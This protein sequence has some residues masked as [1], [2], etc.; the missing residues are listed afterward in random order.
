[1]PL[2]NDLLEV[3]DTLSGGVHPGF[4]PAHARGVM[5]S[6]A[7]TPAPG[8]AELTRAPHAARQS[9]PVTV[10][11]SVSSGIPTVADNDPTGSSPQ[12]MAVR[13]HRADH[14]HT[15]IV[16]H[17]HNGFPARTGEEFLEFLRAAAASGPGGPT[18][19]PIAAFLA[20]HPAAKAF[21]E[22][23]KPIPSSFA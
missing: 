19:P 23:P 14:V 4:R 21:V 3:L 17:S 9:T 18:P 5:Y 22:A 20:T 10:R 7:F 11:F 6:G 16:A 2:I 1:S 12:G 15:D 13:F 8:A